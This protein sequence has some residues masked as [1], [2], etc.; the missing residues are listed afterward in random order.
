MNNTLKKEKKQAAPLFLNAG[1]YQ[2]LPPEEKLGWV[3]V[4]E[5]YEKVPLFS[6][7]SFFIA[8]ICLVFYVITLFSTTFADFFNL[9]IGG[10]VRF[11]L[12]QITNIFPFSVSEMLMIM[13]I[14]GSVIF[15]IYAVNRRSF[16]WK[17]TWSVLSIPLSIIAVIFSLF[18]LTLGAGYK[19]S[20]LD[21]KLDFEKVSVDKDNLYKTAEYLAQNINELCAEQNYGLDGSSQMPYSISQLNEKILDAYDRF[22]DKNDFINTFY[23]KAKPVMLSEGMSHLHTLGIYTFFS[24]EA[25]INVKF[26]DYTTPFTMAHE[27]AHQRGIAREDEANMIAFLVC[28]ESD[29][30][31]IRYSAYLNMYEYVESALGRT[32]KEL[33]IKAHRMLDI[34]VLEEMQ[35]Y[36]DFFSKYYDSG[37]G[38][39]SAAVNDTFLKI[40]G[41]PGQISYGLV[42]ELTV[43]YFHDTGLID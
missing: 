1:E 13:I 27:L 11:I 43:A 32:D 38:K 19:T 30:S 2:E 33:Y 3:P 37:A 21:K 31:Y 8:G 18:V 20:T 34:K 41:T 25:N 35:A 28:M 22:C 16:T 36:S 17:M 9:Y 15:I 14:P 24:G 12:A 40:Q 4:S 42:V 10:A 7:I 5:K 26:P 23:S 39:V 29:D 6:K